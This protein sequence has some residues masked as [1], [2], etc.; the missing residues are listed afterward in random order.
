MG[1]L[2]WAI[3]R[4][5][6]PVV[7][8]P[9]RVLG[10]DLGTTNS[11]VTDIV[12]DPEAGGEP[13]VTVIEVP[14]RTRQAGVDGELVREL[15]PSVVAL[16]DGVELVGEGAHRLRS[17]L[18]GAGL[19]VDEAIWWEQ[20]NWIGTS[21]V[22]PKA[23]PGYRT[24]KEISGRILAH[25]AAAAEDVDDQPIDRIVVTVP[26]SFQLTQRADTLDG[27]AEAGITLQGGDLLDEPVA[28]FLDYVSTS[29]GEHF[30]G[31]AR[32]R[33]LVFDFGGGTCDIAL[34]HVADEGGV[35]QVARRNVSRFHRIGGGDIDLAI[36][37]E[38]LLPRLLEELGIGRF[39]FDFMQKS[40]FILPAL[41]SLAEKLK[42][43]LATEVDRLDSLG[44]LP[45]DEAVQGELRVSLPAPFTFHTGNRDFPTLTLAKPSL[46]L[47]ELRDVT[48]PFVT[49]G[50][51]LPSSKEYYTVTSVFAPIDDALGAAQWTP[52]HVDV[53]LLVGGSSESLLVRQ[54]IRDAFEGAT[55]LTYARPTDAQLAISRG[56]AIHAF[57]RTAFGID[58][59]EPVL[60]EDLAILTDEGPTTVVPAGTVLPF[61][62]DGG[63]HVHDGLVIP[64][65]CTEGT[66]PLRVEFESAGRRLHTQLAAL[67]A[68]LTEGD[69]LPLHVRISADQVMDLTLS[70]PREGGVP[71]TVSVRLDNPFAVTAN[72]NADREEILRLM[73]EV[74]S[75]ARPQQRR[76]LRRMA[77]LHH[78]LGER[79]RARQLLTGL[80]NDAQ[81]AEEGN[82]LNTLGL[83]CEEMRDEEAHL[84]YLRAAIE[85]G[86]ARAAGFNLALALKRYRRFPEALEAIEE[87]IAVE[88]DGPARTL[89]AD[90]LQALGRQDEAENE[91]ARALEMTDDARAARSEFE[92]GWLRSAAQALGRREV[93]REIDGRLKELRASQRTSSG[94]G[95]GGLL[96]RMSSGS[97]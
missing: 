59:I 41:S 1:I 78:G 4:G 88:D 94:G 63:T 90:I 55:L 39:E 32:S 72:P 2:D 33:V 38:V 8:R 49:R 29:G 40:R 48:G 50:F 91:Y 43:K 58:P 77:D 75:V 13:S 34:L 89:R 28:A 71:Q 46:S 19:T 83:L 70:V 86:S 36:A 57:H 60:A 52:E 97:D 10:I 27:A 76:K 26:A 79:E 31:R 35:L 42:I 47:A 92:L 68:P 93:A 25:L 54:A 23:P 15:T 67:H 5:A 61:P 20:K 51:T 7:D 95:G 65:S 22:H 17:D 81:P 11:V 85:R 69:P 14:Q 3:A 30:A 82:L 24:P 66:L 64:E 45:E 80:L 18:L 62:S 56:A 12:W 84:A 37:N 74:P 21:R 87:N 6:Q 53:V 73:Q 9:V 96:P 16:V 44:Q